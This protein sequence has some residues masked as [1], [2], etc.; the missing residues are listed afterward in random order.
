VPPLRSSL[1]LATAL[2]LACLGPQ[3]SNLATHS[4][5]WLLAAADAWQALVRV[6]LG[7]AI[8]L[9]LLSTFCL[10]G[11]SLLLWQQVLQLRKR[12]LR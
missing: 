11:L 6:V 10:V 12:G 4:L 3:T 7:G 9:P 5:A 8:V 1:L 2:L